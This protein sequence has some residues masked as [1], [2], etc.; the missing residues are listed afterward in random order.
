MLQEAAFV[1][2]PQFNVTPP[3]QTTQFFNSRDLDRVGLG[4]LRSGLVQPEAHLSEDALALADSVV[5]DIVI[6]P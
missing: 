2:A 3:C 6:A 5:S 1:Q 4:Y